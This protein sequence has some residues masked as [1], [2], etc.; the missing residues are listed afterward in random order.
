MNVRSSRYRLEQ[1]ELSTSTSSGT[2]SPS[3]DRRSPTCE[4]SSA[5]ISWHPVATSSYRA[6]SNQTKRPT[7]CW[8]FSASRRHQLRK[9]ASTRKLWRH[10]TPVQ[11]IYIYI[12]IYIYRPHFHLSIACVRRKQEER[13]ETACGFWTRRRHWK[14]GT[15]CITTLKVW[16]TP[17]DAIRI[18]PAIG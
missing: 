2:T 13:K 5:A 8:E 16:S 12:Y 10:V 11:S 9:C 6:R 3:L 15:V 14:P 4:R 18:T 7:S 1:P 17:S